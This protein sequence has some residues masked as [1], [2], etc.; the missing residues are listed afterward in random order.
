MMV[1]NIDM[2]HLVCQFHSG[3]NQLSVIPAVQSHSAHP[4]VP[5]KL[6]QDFVADV[7]RLNAISAHTLLHHLQDNLLHLLIW[8]LEFTHQD[9]HDLSGVVVGVHGVH[10]GNNEANGLQEGS[11]HLT[12]AAE[13]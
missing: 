2:P 1:L 8:R 3:L 6:W 7:V 10:E 5:E 4:E 9:D 12:P 11:Q 13:Q